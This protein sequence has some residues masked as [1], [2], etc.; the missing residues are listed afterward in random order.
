M[1]SMAS[2]KIMQRMTE[3]PIQKP[4]ILIVEDSADQ[5]ELLCDALRLEYGWPAGHGPVAVADAAACLAS[6]LDE[7]DVVLLDYHLPD[8]DGLDLLE[9][10]LVRRDLPVIFVTGE[11]DSTT[12]AEAI[13]KG[14]QDYIVKLG[15][16]LFAVPV[17]ID[18]SI[19]QYK[20]RLENR[21]LQQELK[22]MLEELKSK[23]VQLEES[24]GKLQAMAATDHMTGLGNR[25]HFS[26]T[27]ERYYSEAVRYGFD[28]TCCMCDLDHF[29]Q[30]NDTLGHQVGDE[31]LIMAA[32]VVRSNLRRSDNAARYGGDEIVL[33][34]PHTSLALG[35][36]VCQRI[37]RELVLRSLNNSKL[38]HE[39][40]MSIG[41]ASLGE[42]RP[43]SSDALV[44]MADRALYIGKEQGKDR[45]VKFSSINEA[46]PLQA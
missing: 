14:A 13:Q 19:R 42:D 7:F 9:E 36:E 31:V 20:I 16:Y 12:A 8:M 34:L 27:L 30:L 45:I 23:N 2:D 41:I 37:C 44:A 1:A 6:D 32:D 5:R 26:D 43:T 33:L 40:T 46:A 28:L 10:I 29:K 25:R 18:K 4:R 39:V 35:Q 38:R 15:D 24:L 3:K 11:N 21:R 22:E 17:L